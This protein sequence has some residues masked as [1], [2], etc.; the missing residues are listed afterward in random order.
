MAVRRSSR[1]LP[2]G[3]RDGLRVGVLYRRG[4]RAWR[5]QR[6][7]PGCAVRPQTRQALETGVIVRSSRLPATATHHASDRAPLRAGWAPSFAAPRQDVPEK[8]GYRDHSHRDSD[9]GDSR[10]GDDHP[11]LISPQPAHVTLSCQSTGFFIE[12]GLPHRRARWP[13]GPGGRTE[14]SPPARPTVCQAAPPGEASRG[15]PERKRWARSLHAAATSSEM[16]EEVIF[17]FTK[18]KTIYDDISEEVSS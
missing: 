10:S 15:K 16:S 14:R 8:E 12:P 7:E 1:R 5:W 4:S 3:Q 18:P 11:P 17:P 13:N 2:I 9:N 6:L